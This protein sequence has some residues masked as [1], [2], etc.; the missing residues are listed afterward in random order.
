MGLFCSCP[1]VTGVWL[2]S[3]LGLAPGHRLWP[4]LRGH[5]ILG[6]SG[7]LFLTGTV[8][9]ASPSQAAPAYTPLL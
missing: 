3:D 9:Y 4:E 8:G 6:K 7:H 1:Q 2:L 5:F